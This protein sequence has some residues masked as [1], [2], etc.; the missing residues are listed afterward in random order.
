MTVGDVGC[1]K[2][3]IGD[4]LCFGVPWRVYYWVSSRDLKVNSRIRC[5]GF[6]APSMFFLWVVVVVVVG[7]RLCGGVGQQHANE[8]HCCAA[9]FLATQILL[10]EASTKVP[11]SSM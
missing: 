9:T 4:P 8:A 6:H 10:A 2:M 1:P 11:R 7:S 5:S 3:I